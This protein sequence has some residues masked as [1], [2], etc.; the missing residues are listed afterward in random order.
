MPM[1]KLPNRK[2]GTIIMDPPTDIYQKG[3]KDSKSRSAGKYYDLMTIEQIKAMPIPD[4][5]AE[6]AH[7][8]LWTTNAALEASYGLLRA[9]NL[10]PRSIFS[11]IKPG[12]GLGVYLRNCSEQ[13]LLAT[14]GK[15]P[16]LFNAQPN[17]GY[18]PRQDHSHKPEEVY[19]IIERCSPGPFLELFARRHRHGWDAWGNEIDSDIDIPGYPVPNSPATRKA[20]AEGASNE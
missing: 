15:A 18:F 2:Y 4:L 11:W 7:L 14:R 17:W 19:S 10:T 12:M 13:M 5:L 6:N 1:D 8:Y 16:I 3:K 9:W 20:A